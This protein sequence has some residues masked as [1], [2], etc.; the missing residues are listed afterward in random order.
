M[1]TPNFY[2]AVYAI[3]RNE[4]GEVLFSQRKN[5]GFMDGKYQ[6]PAGHMDGNETMAF[7]MARELKEEIDIDVQEKDMKVVHIS[8]RI[9]LGGREYFDVYLEVLNYTGTPCINEPEKCSALDYFDINSINSTDFVLYDVDV[10]EMVDSGI[11]FSDVDM[12][13]SE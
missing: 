7:A 1:S 10:I 11:S 5:T 9:S 12:G 4:K 6:L 3:I 13:E 2:A 8:H